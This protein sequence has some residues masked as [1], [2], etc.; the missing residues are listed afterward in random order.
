MGDA[1]ASMDRMY[2]WQ[3]HIYDLTRKPYLLG[4]DLLISELRP[5][6][7]GSI[8]EIGCGTGRN[9]LS[10]SRLYPGRRWFGLDVSAVMLGKAQA[11]A[12]ERAPAERILFRQADATNFDPEHLFGVS[13]FD[14]VYVSYALSMI[15]EW[16][17]VLEAGLR[18]T[19]P[20]GSL[21]VA[22]FGDQAGLPGLAKL[23]LNRWLEAFDV[24]P[25]IDLRRAMNLGAAAQGGMLTDFRSLYRG[26]AAFGRIEL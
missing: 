16:R 13:Q 11:N 8:L 6:T 14:R 21:L 22:D 9:L 24:H 20:R 7:G 4:R 15:P 12:A 3:R 26:Y 5:P 23:V 25:R 17:S 18:A 2:R 1:A 10:A 19:A